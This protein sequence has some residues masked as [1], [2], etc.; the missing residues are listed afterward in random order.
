MLH[1]K[2]KVKN[3]NKNKNTRKYQIQSSVYFIY[4]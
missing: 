3:K 2:V 4:R 1:C